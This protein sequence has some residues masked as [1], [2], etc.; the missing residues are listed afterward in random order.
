MKK[1]K[2]KKKKRK[3]TP[4]TTSTIQSNVH[5]RQLSTK[6]VT[7]STNDTC[8]KSVVTD[9]DVVETLHARCMCAPVYEHVR[10]ITEETEECR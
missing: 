3:S 9:A 8:E 2:K 1:K 6:I 10:G 7:E 5:S 4:S